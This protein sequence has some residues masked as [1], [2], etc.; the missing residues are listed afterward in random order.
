MNQHQ[1]QPSPR[2]LVSIRSAEEL[3]SALTGGADW[4]DLKEPNDG[5]LAPVTRKVALET[6]A[7]LTESGKAPLSAALGELRDWNQSSLD[8][9]TVPG[10]SVVKLGLAGCAIRE[11]WQQQWET[12]FQE[13]KD[14]DKLLAAVIYADYEQAE[15][16]TPAEV[17]EVASAAG[18]KILLIDTFDKQAGSTFA[19]LPQRELHEILHTAKQASMTT[20]LAGSL[21]LA[22]I[23]QVPC[24]LVDIIAVRGAVCRGER[25]QAVSAELVAGLRQQL[26]SVWATSS[27]QD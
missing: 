12:I 9:L 26:T 20:V 15:S 19:H 11:S 18:C 25:T 2:L 27:I 6:A 3:L 13:S 23:R 1:A 14:N 21:T 7:M 22:S 4:I 8:F 24:E 5:P 17:L 10:V 16:P